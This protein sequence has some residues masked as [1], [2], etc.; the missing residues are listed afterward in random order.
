MFEVRDILDSGIV[1]VIVG[2]LA[3]A[4][5]LRIVAGMLDHWRIGNY[6]RARHGELR[7]CRWW[8]FGPGW[9][10]EKRDR[11]YSVTF[12]DGAGAEH[13]AYC[14]TSLLTGVYFT[15]D[16]ISRF[17]EESRPDSYASLNEEVLRLR[18]ENQGLRE[19]IA[20]Q[21]NADR[22]VTS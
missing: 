19:E 9:L 21:K 1:P 5:G 11:I 20:R 22:G 18:A 14:K 12:I 8:P 6:I 15:Q 7:S 13:R 10:G 2:G 3:F 4:L 16:R 17:S